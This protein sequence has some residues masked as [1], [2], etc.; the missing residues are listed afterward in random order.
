MNINQ[1][2]RVISKLSQ[3]AT[4]SK[5]ALLIHG[6]HGIGKSEVVK[7]VTKELGIGFID[8]RAALMEVGDIIGL[9]STDS[10]VTTFNPP[11]ILPQDPNSKG[12]LFLDEFNR[13]KLDVINC[14]FQLVLD[15]KVNQYELPV[16]WIV[17]SA[18]NPDT[19]NYN[20]TSLS[21]EATKDRFLHVKLSPTVDE[22]VT[23]AKNNPKLEQ[24]MVEF[25]QL[26]PDSLDT[27]DM[28]EYSLERKTSRRSV[29]KAAELLNLGF[30]ADL[31]QELIAGLIGIETAAAYM[32]FR[33]DRTTRPFTA[34][35][36][37]FNYDKISNQLD[38][39]AGTDN[40]RMD[41]LSVTIDNV[42][43]YLIKN[44]SNRALVSPGYDNLYKF[45]AKI[46]KD[47]A[48]GMIQ[49]FAMA[50]ASLP[51]NPVMLDIMNNIE[52]EGLD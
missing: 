39:Y 3:E 24:T 43:E 48:Y 33:K 13:A 2:K 28:Q 11:A 6:N 31:E 34:E 50:T 51:D 18:V 27:Q 22:W 44:V 30:D 16:G 40:Q 36:I 21:D 8:F 26:N 47:K 49:K 9:P 41:V 7:Q 32:A 25:I 1:L 42:C 29:S 12:I 52:L 38:V 37:L 45:A 20:V 17:V 19:E 5:V 46:P 10:N 35:E 15:N 23:Y 4:T 14:C